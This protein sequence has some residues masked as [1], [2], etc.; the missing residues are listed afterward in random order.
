[1]SKSREMKNSIERVIR[2]TFRVMTNF[3]LVQM[4][5]SDIVYFSEVFLFCGL[6]NYQNIFKS[7]VASAYKKTR[8]KSHSVSKAV[9]E[10]V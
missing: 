8:L 6:K 5:P 9:Q 10:S 1:M 4:V 3:F 2:Q 7:N